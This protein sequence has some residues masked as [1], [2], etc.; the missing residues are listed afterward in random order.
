MRRF[1]CPFPEREG[2]HICLPDSWHGSHATRRDDAVQEARENNLPNT[3]RTFAVAMALLDDWNIKEL[4]RNP[5]LWDFENLDLKVI[6][7]INAVVMDDFLAC[8]KVPKVS[9]S[10]SPNGAK[11]TPKTTKEPVGASESEM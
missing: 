6:A 11:V 3:Y 5:E 1:D 9:L 4:P 2:E 8:W 7:W 10:P